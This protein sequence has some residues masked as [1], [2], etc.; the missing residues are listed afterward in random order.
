MSRYSS[1]CDS[2][3]VK[4]KKA[5]TGHFDSDDE[6]METDDPR[7]GAFES[8]DY[9][10]GYTR[11]YTSSESED[12]PHVAP[13]DAAINLATTSGTVCKTLE[14][15]KEFHL[16]NEKLLAKDWLLT[17]DSNE[18]EE[19]C[20]NLNENELLHW[21]YTGD[22]VTNIVNFSH[23]MLRSS[24]KTSFDLFRYVKWS[25]LKRLMINA[26]VNYARFKLSRVNCFRNLQ[27]LEVSC[28]TGCNDHLELAKLLILRIDA[29]FVTNLR[30]N[31]PKLRLL[32]TNIGLSQLWLE[33]TDSI[34]HLH[35]HCVEESVL[36][37]KHLECLSIR[38]ATVRFEHIIERL[39][40]LVK[41]VFEP[42]ISP[43][44]IKRSFMHILQA[45]LDEKRRLNRRDLSFYLNRKLIFSIERVYSDASYKFEADV[46]DQFFE[47]DESKPK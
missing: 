8:D 4:F 35:I 16:L 17:A 40:S 47:C 31:L 10:G 3:Y 21:T 12:T 11:Y 27:H 28:Y 2:D 43:N 15:L 22:R 32:E 24:E 13:T 29:A 37:F 6:P 7:G 1:D 9:V 30:A 39:P 19:L 14:L 42:V 18:M 5:T 46:P 33:K 44:V 26:P 38:N 34:R 41:V 45:L 23:Q 36:K 20:L 25:G